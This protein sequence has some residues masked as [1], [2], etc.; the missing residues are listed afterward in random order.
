M[1]TGKLEDNKTNPIFIIFYWNFGRELGL[2]T[3]F[4]REV[5][6]NSSLHNELKNFYQEFLK[7]NKLFHLSG[8]VEVTF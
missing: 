6:W 2:V 1:T 4:N 5:G 8:K 3:H 7:Y